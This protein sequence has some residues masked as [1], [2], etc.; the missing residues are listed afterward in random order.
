L[1]DVFR[2]SIRQA[3]A[4]FEGCS[5]STALHETPVIGVL[6]HSADKSPVRAWAIP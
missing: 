4:A 5:V 3:Q 1:A 6:I 2:S